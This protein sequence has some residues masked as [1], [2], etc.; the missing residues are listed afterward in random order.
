MAAVTRSLMVNVNMPHLVWDS[1]EIVAV[2]RSAAVAD[3]L[4]VLIE[5]HGLVDV[6]DDAAGVAGWPA[7]DAA[8]RHCDWRFFDSWP[9]P[10]PADHLTVGPDGHWLHS[11][12]EDG[13]PE[14]D[15]AGRRCSWHLG[16][17]A[18]SRLGVFDPTVGKWRAL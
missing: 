15:A 5:A 13:W 7:P 6:P 18:V 2:C 12:A 11:P 1:G 14:P 10:C 8:T 17:G 16:P 3:R 9:E 4:V